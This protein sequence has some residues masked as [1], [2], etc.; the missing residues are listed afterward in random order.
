MLLLNTLNEPDLLVPDNRIKIRI[1]NIKGQKCTRFTNQVDKFIDVPNPVQ[2][3]LNN[4]TPSSI[5]T[6]CINIPKTN[7]TIST[8]VNRNDY[9]YFHRN[10]AEYSRIRTVILL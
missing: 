10:F 6:V 9:P 5:I 7:G 8:Q 3:G 4:S 1:I 2:S